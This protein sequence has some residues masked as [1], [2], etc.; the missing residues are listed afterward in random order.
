MH[1]NRVAAREPDRR[2]FQKNLLL[3]GRELGPEIWRIPKK[4]QECPL[5]MMKDGIDLMQLPLGVCANPIQRVVVQQDRI[6]RRLQRIDM[7]AACKVAEAQTL[8]GI[9]ESRGQNLNR[10]CRCCALNKG[11]SDVEW[12]HAPG[13]MSQPVE[14]SR[15]ILTTQR[16]AAFAADQRE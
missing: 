14:G 4:R 1:W 6:R 12:L 5:G 9:L 2:R 3:L 16:A 11:L 7:R 15:N 8:H 13:V 10:R